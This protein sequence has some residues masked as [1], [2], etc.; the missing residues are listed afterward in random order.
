MKGLV[1]M[2]EKTKKV[3]W[4][5]ESNY[6]SS[7]VVAE[8]F[9]WLRRDIDTTFLAV[10]KCIKNQSAYSSEIKFSYGVLFCLFLIV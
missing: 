1:E 5:K 8:H 7:L 2:T 4:S 10:I 3:Y 9:L 6:V